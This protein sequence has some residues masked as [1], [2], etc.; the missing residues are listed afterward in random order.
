[1]QAQ[2]SN[3]FGEKEPELASILSLRTHLR[4]QLKEIGAKDSR[5]SGYK[6]A[7]ERFALSAMVMAEFYEERGGPA[8]RDAIEASI[9]TRSFRPTKLAI[10]REVRE[11]TRSGGLHPGMATIIRNVTFG[12]TVFRLDELADRIV[13]ASLYRQALMEKRAIEQRRTVRD[14]RYVN[15]IFDEISRILKE[16]AREREKSPQY[17]GMRG[18]IMHAITFQALDTLESKSRRDYT[19]MGLE[20]MGPDPELRMGHMINYSA[21]SLET[22]GL[23]AIIDQAMLE[24]KGMKMHD[25][26]LL[27]P[28]LR[29]TYH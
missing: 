14:L 20:F 27:V 8:V 11:E 15:P 26:R 2:A 9:F 6:T 24:R 4:S 16:H 18:W 10:L 12:D 17:W 28:L 29:K 5:R 23:I 1:M 13:E 7:V 3:V 25:E 22:A 21:R 19:R